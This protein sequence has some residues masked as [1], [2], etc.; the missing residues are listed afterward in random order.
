[1]TERIQ[2][3]LA[4]AD[5]PLTRK[6]RSILED[7]PTFRFQ[8]VHS[9]ENCLNSI[10]SEGITW[11]MVYVIESLRIGELAAIRRIIGIY[12]HIRLIAVTTGEPE[13]LS[14]AFQAGICGHLD[15]N[16]E[17]SGIID[18]VRTAAGGGT[19][20]SPQMAAY[21][22]GRISRRTDSSV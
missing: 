7:C 8:Y 2:V 5:G 19:V 6:I 4:G 20:L 10:R 16:A 13:L 12:P 3:L 18:A 11:V 17:D 21:I 9:L 22:L 14:T 1:M 15:A